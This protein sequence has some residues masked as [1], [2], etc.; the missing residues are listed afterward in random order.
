MQLSAMQLFV[1]VAEPVPESS[2]PIEPSRS[3]SLIIIFLKK[4]L[5]VRR[6]NPS[7]LSLR[8]NEKVGLDIPLV[9]VL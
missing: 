9:S 4:G 1:L 8:H 3:S 6:L 2:I 5:C 7:A